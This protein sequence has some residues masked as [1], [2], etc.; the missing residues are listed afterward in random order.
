MLSLLVG[1][2]LD[3]C[4]TARWSLHLDSCLEMQACSHVNSGARGPAV[5]FVALSAA[6]LVLWKSSGTMLACCSSSYLKADP[7]LSACK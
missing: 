7:C 5:P 1:L 2:M 3:S 4:T 6:M